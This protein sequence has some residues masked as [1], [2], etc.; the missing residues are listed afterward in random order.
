MNPLQLLN[1][2]T[3]E[4]EVPFKGLMYVDVVVNG[5][6]TRAMVDSGATNN[7]MAEREAKRLGLAVVKT[8]YKF[9]A[10]NSEKSVLGSALVDLKVGEWCGECNLM[11]VPLDDFD[12]ILGIE[13][14]VKTRASVIPHLRGV[15]IGD[16]Q[17]PCFVKTVLEGSS[18]NKK[19]LDLQSGKQFKAGLKKGEQ[20]YVAALVEIKHDQIIEIPD[21]VAAVLEEFSMFLVACVRFL[22]ACALALSFIFQTLFYLFHFN[23][24][25]NIGVSFSGVP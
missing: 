12:M 8:D 1:A 11:V 6:E 10:V 14:L 2:I 7:F 19:E 22:S 4:K 17:M 16:E 24:I 3:T 25:N 15:M 18:K 23:F 5:K 20:A 21:A 9:K 13:F